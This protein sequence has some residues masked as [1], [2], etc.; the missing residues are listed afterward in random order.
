[1]YVRY[2]PVLKSVQALGYKERSGIRFTRECGAHNRDKFPI[3]EELFP[4]LGI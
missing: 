3:T 4:A 2:E 1:M